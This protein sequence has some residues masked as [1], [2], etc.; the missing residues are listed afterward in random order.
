M[1][2]PRSCVTGTGL[3]AVLVLVGAALREEGPALDAF[4]LAPRLAFGGRPGALELVAVTSAPPPPA[5]AGPRWRL[6]LESPLRLQREGRRVT[7]GR[8]DA[9][10]FARAAVWRVALLAHFYGGVERPVELAPLQ[11]VLDR[12]TAYDVDLRWW[13]TRR[14]SS[15]QNRRFPVGGLLGRF[16]LDLTACP[17]LVPWL[18]A[19]LPLGL[20]R[21]T[22]IGCGVV[23]PAPAETVRGS[24]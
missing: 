9:R 20:G 6:P 1:P 13:E 14:G 24:S 23:R 17:E 3:H 8:F 7:P 22:T 15:R 16:T 18:E 2:R 10:T 12:A 21:S 4:A 5:P 19:A 11:R